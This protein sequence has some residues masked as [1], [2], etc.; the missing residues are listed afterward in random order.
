MLQKKTVRD[1]T[2]E[3]Q[4]V[5]LRCDFN[6][7]LDEN[8]VIQDNSRIVK[9]L[10]TIKYILK[11]GSKLILA[12]HLGRPK[13]KVDMKY[14]LKPV[15]AEL[16]KLLLMPVIMSEDVCGQDARTKAA[17]LK[18]GEILLLENVRFE[19]GETKND[20]DLASRFASLADIYVN[21][22]FGTAHRAHSSTVGI[23]K[24]LPSYAGFLIEK[25]IQFLKNAIDDS[26][27]PLM[28]ILGGAKVSDKIWVI[29]NLI[30]KVDTILV[31]GAMVFTMYRALGI[32]TGKSLVEEDQ[33]EVAKQIFKQA[34]AKNVRIILPVDIVVAKEDNLDEFK[35]VKVSQIP[36]NMKGLDIGCET[37]KNFDLEIRKAKTII[38]NGPLG[39]FENPN[40]KK[41]TESIAQS[42]ADTD[43][44]SIVG[45]GDSASAIKMLGLEDKF[46]HISTG[47]G[48]SLEFLEGKKLPGIVA[49]LDK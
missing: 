20:E 8:G 22:A 30:D 5:F 14:S 41:G 10:E 16:E 12:S 37:I 11:K 35:T 2:F 31:G 3:N 18:K 34:V 6:V 15:Q 24:Y 47:G 19:P 33:V 28:A 44:I 7:P 46:S 43:C 32:P 26:E 9:S 40:F 23:T 36:E 38:W 21:D 29:L 39:L 4:T 13:G 1:A 48:A 27:R 17:M 45:G 49:L 25:E 42:I